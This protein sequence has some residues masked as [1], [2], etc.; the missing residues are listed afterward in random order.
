MASAKV[1]PDF[2]DPGYHALATGRPGRNLDPWICGPDL[3]APL[4][5]RAGEGADLLVVEGVMGLFDGSATP[6]MAGDPID[7]DLASTAQVARLLDAPVLLVVDAASASRSIAAVVHGFTTFD[8]TLRTGGVILNRIGS[9]THEVMVREALA[10]LGIAVLGALHR[11]EALT[12]RDRHL[13]LVPVIEQPEIVRASLD[14]LATMIERRCDI[15]A[16]STLAHKAPSLIVDPPPAARALHPI[17]N[18]RVRIAVVGGPAF[19]FTYA[20][21]LELLEQAGAELVTLDPVHDTELPEGTSG[22]VAGGGFPE[23]HADALAAN[24]PLLD[25]V[26]ERIRGGLVTWAECGGMLWL[27]RSLDGRALADVLPTRAGMTKRLTLGYRRAVL[28]RD[29]PLGPKGTTLWGH[30]FHYS[31]LDAPGDGM[32]LH[33]RTGETTAGWV[34]PGLIAS[35]LHLHLGAAPQLAEH[36]VRG[37]ALHSAG[38]G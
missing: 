29:S 2:I 22:L 10:G 4:A 23:I 9:D 17:A 26:H 5:G 13:G 16:I 15:Q 33:G 37:C 3:M 31:D 21:N 32:T 28:R 18:R 7:P 30:E 8:A 27:A 19:S 14:R 24:Q 12:W 25:D 20:D 11:D 36:F 34:S 38:S 6:R 35:Y 1:G